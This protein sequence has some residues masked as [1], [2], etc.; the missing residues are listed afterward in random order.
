MKSAIQIHLEVVTAG[1]LKIFQQQAF[2]SFASHVSEVSPIVEIGV[3]AS[4]NYA[5]VSGQFGTFT[6]G[7][8]EEA[9]EKYKSLII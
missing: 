1:N 6:Y 9:I 7:T 2:I 5:V 3:T 8:P 4:G